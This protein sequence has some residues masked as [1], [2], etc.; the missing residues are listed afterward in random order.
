MAM[1]AS[2]YDVDNIDNPESYENILEGARDEKHFG[3]N[4]S[5]IR[6]EDKNTIE[7]RVPNGT[8][9][10]ETLMN[11]IRLYG[12]MMFVSKDMVLNPEKYKEKFD[13]YR[14]R[15]LSERD[16]LEALLDLLFESDEVKD[17]YRQRWDSVKD[18][19]IYDEISMG[20]TTFKRGDYTLSKYAKKCV[21]EVRTTDIKDFRDYME[22][23]KRKDDIELREDKSS[24]I[25]D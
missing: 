1:D 9:D 12:T 7:F 15:S 10:R 8:I 6:S 4:L 5:N 23:R 2:I 18:E 19:E 11:N 3:L 14:D 20:S 13:A 21:S 17:I 24:L 22:K 25:D 16:K